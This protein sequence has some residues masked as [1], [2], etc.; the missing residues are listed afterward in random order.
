M[1]PLEAPAGSTLT[2]TI[3]QNSTLD[4]HTLGHFRLSTADDPQV[5]E[6][7]RTP[8]AVLDALRVPAANRQPAQL[9]A[10]S[11]H[12]LN[13]APELEAT[14]KQLATVKQ[15]LAELKP[16]TVPIL[17]ELP[18]GQRRVTKIQH[19]GNFLDLGAD[20]TEGTPVTFPPLPEG[21]P[22][23]RLTLSKWIMSD[24]NP[25]TA[26]VIANR[27]WEQIFGIGIVLTSEEFGSQGDQPFHPELLDWL[28]TEMVRL[29]W[30]T[31]AFLRLLGTK[32]TQE[33]IAY[34]LKTGKPL[35]N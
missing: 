24:E 29:K 35:R 21:A 13:I 2:V 20:V 10:I 3:E 17:K 31:K 19:R 11:Q 14:R 12:F 25:L 6:W 34:T 33:R 18:M 23:D 28:A 15:Q 22:R 9:A 16:D 27:Y 32:E 8:P 30:D 7:V 4:S 26:R 1:P 5:A